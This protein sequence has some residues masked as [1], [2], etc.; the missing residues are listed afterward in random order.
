MGFDQRRRDVAAPLYAN[1]PERQIGAAIGDA[2]SSPPRRGLDLTA[3]PPQADI[4]YR[5]SGLQQA[6]A[7]RHGSPGS[8]SSFEGACF[9]E[10]GKFGAGCAATHRSAPSRN[11]GAVLRG[12]RLH[13]AI[14]V[15]GGMSEQR[16]DHDQPQHAARKAQQEQPQHDRPPDQQ[17]PQ[18]G[19]YQRHAAGPSR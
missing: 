10:G 17:H 3:Q 8:S 7:Q 19:P 5:E 4:G 11:R 12:S 18:I 16:V 2:V 9:S 13:G 6:V 14:G 15:P 1:A